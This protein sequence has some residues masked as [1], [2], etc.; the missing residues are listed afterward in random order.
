[1]DYAMPIVWRRR[2][3]QTERSPAGLWFSCIASVDLWKRDETMWMHQTSII[4]MRESN[5]F[6]E[7]HLDFT[8]DD[9]VSEFPSEALG[10]FIMGQCL[11]DLLVFSTQSTDIAWADWLASNLEFFC[12]MRPLLRRS[13]LILQ[14]M[15]LPSISGDVL[16]FPR[17]PCWE[18]ISSIFFVNLD[19]PNHYLVEAYC[20]CDTLK[21]SDLM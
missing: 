6:V 16:H 4:S 3:L 8:G 18:C 13:M 9:P 5:C 10:S 7:I 14:A 17:R 20:A 11:C 12:P 19:L 2:P 1:M 21:S 15:I